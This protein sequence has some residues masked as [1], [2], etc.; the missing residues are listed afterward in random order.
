[1]FV[2]QF[3]KDVQFFQLFFLLIRR[4]CPIKNIDL[5]WTEHGPTGRVGLRHLGITEALASPHS[6][7]LGCCEQNPHPIYCNIINDYGRHEEESCG[8]SDRI[9]EERIRRSH[10]TQVYRCRFGLID[11]AVP[12]IVNGQHI[13]TLFTGQVHRSA[14]TAEEFVQISKDVARLDYVDL[15][16]LE[17][18]Y[19]D[20]PVVSEE[21]IRNTIEILEG[22]AAYLANSWVRLA[23]TVSERRRKDR[24][25]RLSR[26]EFA[27]HALEGARGGADEMRDLVRKAGFTRPP[28]RVLVVRLESA[29]G[30][31]DA[32]QEASSDLGLASVLQ[33]IEELSDKLENVAAA[34][35]SKS[36][37]CV[38]FHDSPAARGRVRDLPAQRLA[39]RILHAVWERC[40][41]PVRIGI[42][43]AKDD[44]PALAQS[45]REACTAI[46]GSRAAIAAYQ[47]RKHSLKELS[48]RSEQ[49]SRLVAQRKL[50][51]AR[52][53]I[54]S[55]PA[56]V[57][58]CL[59]TRQEDLASAGLFF[60]FALESLCFAA[61]DLGC[62]AETIASLGGGAGEELRAASD[63]LQMHRTWLRA[64]GSI[65]QEARLL[66]SG[67]REKIVGRARRMIEHHLEQ[68]S[69]QQLS[70]SAIA[71]A[72]S[73]SPGHLSRVFKREAR[74]TFES[75]LT[76]RRVELARRLLLDPLHNVC[77]VA[78]RCGFADASYFARVF[79]R[80]AGCSPR[81]YR[82]APLRYGGAAAARP[83][84]SRR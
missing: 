53:V 69:R 35:L 14:P 78:H 50:E 75:Y 70:L 57:S 64:A 26:K 63:L 51:E 62:D 18:A 11:I 68:G 15:A 31:D 2:E 54:E 55:L 80:V 74:Q 83:L 30:G 48:T 79:R 49:I 4:C 44:W 56:L 28:N 39:N 59:G 1:L 84:K 5:V 36:G 12:V 76:A 9:A 43:G 16:Q 33:A 42:G 22:F 25:L 7:L 72:L 37:I 21:E 29:E 73:V 71:A 52:T 58:R 81:Q 65:L 47:Q 32:A 34:H 20:V 13:A 60:S 23:E 8:A 40:E 3:E 45:Y 24:E 38:F 41:L 46:A 77:E 17:R 10:T 6:R 27:Y 19:W 66:Y 82:E 67:R 61:R